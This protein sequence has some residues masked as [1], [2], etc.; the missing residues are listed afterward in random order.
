V[1]ITP[2]RSAL[3]ADGAAVVAII[4]EFYAEW[5]RSHANNP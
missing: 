4:A 5:E 3:L 1:D 2:V